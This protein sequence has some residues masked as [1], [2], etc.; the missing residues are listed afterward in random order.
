MEG[1]LPRRVWALLYEYTRG[2]WIDEGPRSLGGMVDVGS[3]P[4]DLPQVLG[5][6]WHDPESE[7]GVAWRR[8]RGR[9]AWI[10]VPVRAPAD[11]QM[12]VRARATG[13]P[14]LLRV[15][16]N[17]HDGGEALL[18]ADWGEHAFAVP[19]SALRRGFNDVRVMTRPAAEGG[20]GSVAVDW[21]R[22]T[23]TA[24]RPGPR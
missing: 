22:F 11:Y 2:I 6:G 17:E 19:S 7:D 15:D 14:M 18:S 24:V 3:E 1:R 10:R 21:I 12:V 16:V 23:R 9:R 4:P 8:L 5:P 20:A 13:A